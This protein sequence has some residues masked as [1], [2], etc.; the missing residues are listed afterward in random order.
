MAYLQ[1]EEAKKAKAK[2]MKKW[3]AEHKDKVREAQERYWKKKAQEMQ[4]EEE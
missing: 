2:Y 4:S 3:R 1:T